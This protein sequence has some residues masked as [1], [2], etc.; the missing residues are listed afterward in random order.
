MGNLSMYYWAGFLPQRGCFQTEAVA[1]V[2]AALLSHQSALCV[3]QNGPLPA[4][5]FEAPGLSLNYSSMLS[6]EMPF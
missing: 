6:V 4:G 1:M 5:P 3:E 2:S